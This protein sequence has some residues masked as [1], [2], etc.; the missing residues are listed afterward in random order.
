MFLSDEEMDKIHKVNLDILIK[1]DEICKKYNLKYSLSSGT[2]LGAVRNGKFIPWDDDVDVMM[3]R[4]DYEKLIAIAEKEKLAENYSLQHYKT[5]KYAKINWAKFGNDN[6]TWIDDKKRLFPI[7]YGIRIDIFP[8]DRIKGK[9]SH[10]IYM[11]KSYKYRVAR[12]LYFHTC[13]PLAFRIFYFPV[14]IVAKM[15]G[16]Q[17]INRKLDKFDKKHNK[18]NFTCADNINRTKLMPYSV[19]EEFSTIEFEGKKFQCVKDT[20]TYLSTMYGENYITPP[21]ENKRRNHVDDNTIIDCDK[22]WKE[23]LKG[24]K[25]CKH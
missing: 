19:F 1:F 3:P 11:V 9:F 25:L 8:V 15:M 14:M 21:A 12:V 13:V 23:Y 18:G 17:R 7:S 16:I 5:E 22:S 10:F 24:A 6:S 2:L 4:E 20:N